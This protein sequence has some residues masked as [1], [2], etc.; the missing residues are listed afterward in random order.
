MQKPHLT[1]VRF[2]WELYFFLEKRRKMKKRRRIQGK[3]TKLL[4]SSQE[5]W[6]STLLQKAG[7]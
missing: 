4:L 3:L 2:K 6:D 7:P 1:V 5:K